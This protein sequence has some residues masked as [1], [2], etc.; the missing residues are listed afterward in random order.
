MRVAVLVA[1]VL[2]LGLLVLPRR[3]SSGSRFAT[4]AELRPLRARRA[5][6]GGLPLGSAAL[7]RWHPV[8]VAL[9]TPP[10][11]SVL[12]L[13]PTGSG[14]T[15]SLIIPA[16]LSWRGPI[17]AASVKDDLA[18]ATSRWRATAG[19]LAVLSPAGGGTVRFD[20]VALATDPAAAAR[21]ATSLA[22]GAAGGTT[23]GEMAFWS[24]LASKLLAGLLL[25][26]N[27]ASGDLA[28]VARW[29]EG[30]TQDEPLGWL[31]GPA[32]EAAWRSLVASFAREERQLGSVV[33]TA[34]TLIDPLL[35]DAPVDV[36]D[37]ERLLDECGTLYL[38]AP[39]HDQRRFASL[40]AAT[41]D[42]VLRV[43]FRRAATE[44]G[45]LRQPL[46]V[47]LDEA[48]AIA[49]LA[50]LDV[51]AA[52]CAGQGITL[53]TCFQDLAQV[54]A[55]WG[56]AAGTLVNN[57]RT[58]VILGGLADP[59]AAELVMA[60]GGVRRGRARADGPAPPDRPLIDA[61]ELRQMPVRSGLVIS[62]SVPMVRLRLRPWWQ[63][64]GLADRGD[65]VRSGRPGPRGARA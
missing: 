42:E 23:T 29:L 54:R 10:G 5:R 44:G 26:A 57:H 28:L 22:L 3:P 17:L 41:T 52:T 63:H 20:P 4:L 61:H 18:R 19:P 43:A 1:G 15:T 11:E 30:R 27:R 6:A 46:L 56:E 48:A 24:Q 59:S 13:G 16:V 8:P 47:V 50:E 7:G 33:A 21:V 53:M 58:R 35:G 2:G 49:P 36:L 12:I 64:R 65:R 37:P 9:H 39:A 14:K 34:E 51:L 38:C 25:A 60:L 45:R 32:D 62:G 40:F 31:T 55:R